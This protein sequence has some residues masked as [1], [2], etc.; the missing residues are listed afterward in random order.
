MLFQNSTAQFKN[1]ITYDILIFS[2][3]KQL[4]TI[5]H[6]QNKSFCLQ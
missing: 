4:I 1:Y 3:V 2:A 5:N 6:I